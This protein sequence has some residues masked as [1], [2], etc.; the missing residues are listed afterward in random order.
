MTEL[1]NV[2]HTEAMTEGE[3]WVLNVLA[4]RGPLDTAE[5]RSIHGSL[6][7]RGM[8]GHYLLAG[9]EDM[10]LILGRLPNRD[11]RLRVYE[12]VEGEDD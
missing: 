3:Q 8:P 2:E 1:E 12:L 4:L 11:S 6:V 5:L 9:L 10:G 7:P